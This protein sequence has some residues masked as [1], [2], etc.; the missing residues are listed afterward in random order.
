M[1]GGVREWMADIHGE[2][3]WAEALAEPEPSPDT[4]RGDSA[5]RVIRS[6][7]WISNPEY[8]RS[9]A[10]SRFFALTRGTGLGFRIARSIVRGTRT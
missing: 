8:C 2:H 9:A 6:G 7:N 4:Q 1:A 10:R 3:T 5:W